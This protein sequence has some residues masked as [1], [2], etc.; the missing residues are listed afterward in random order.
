MPELNPVFSSRKRLRVL[1]L[2]PPGKDAG[3]V[4]GF[5]RTLCLPTHYLYTLVG[6]ENVGQRFLSMKTARQQRP[7]WNDRPSG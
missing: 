3:P 7:D 6:R 1:L 2:P 5:P 4:E